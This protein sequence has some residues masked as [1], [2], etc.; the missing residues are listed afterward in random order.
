MQDI[1][2][3]FDT[4]MM[5]VYLAAKRDCNYH[6]TYFF[7][8]L[9]ELRGLATAKRLLAKA[10]AQYG[11][12][13]LHECRCLHLTVECLVLR[14]KYRPLFDEAELDRARKRLK[15]HGFDFGRCEC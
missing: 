12:E 13:K 6:A 9:H 11:F 10:L 15:A 3:Q 1:V 5:G 8:M 14:R 2:R 7:N 4:D